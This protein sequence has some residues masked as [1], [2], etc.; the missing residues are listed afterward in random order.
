VMRWAIIPFDKFNNLAR[1][2]HIHCPVLVIHGRDDRIVPFWHGRT[3]YST[4]NEPKMHCWV[5]HAGHNDLVYQA[6]DEYWKTLS[7]FRNLIQTTQDKND[8]ANQ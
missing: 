4:A 1:I 2:G 6:G 7:Q 8:T 3:L 5:E